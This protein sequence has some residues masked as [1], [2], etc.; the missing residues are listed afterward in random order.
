MHEILKHNDG[1]PVPSMAGWWQR[2]RAAVVGAVKTPLTPKDL[3]QLKMLRE[4]LGR[5]SFYVMNWVWDNWS[6]FSEKA[7]DEAGL[8]SAPSKP[9][10]GFLLSHHHRAV[11]LMYEAAKSK[12]SVTPEDISFKHT[13]EHMMCDLLK[14]QEEY[15]KMLAQTEALEPAQ[16]D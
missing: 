16:N 11:N 8:S 12:P 1:P 9:H 7:K 5:W 4:R 15:L 6:R 3:G 14:K 13:V 10:I 2:R